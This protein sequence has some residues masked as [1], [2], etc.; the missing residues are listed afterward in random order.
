MGSKI[1]FPLNSVFPT[2]GILRQNPIDDY[3]LEAVIRKNMAALDDE[4]HRYLSGVVY[5]KFP[6]LENAIRTFQK[7]VKAEPQESNELETTYTALKK[8]MQAFW[9]AMENVAAIKSSGR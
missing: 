6:Q 9:E 3:C 7:A 5:L 4:L 2:R 1:I 8:S